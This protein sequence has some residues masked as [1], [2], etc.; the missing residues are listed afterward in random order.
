[1]INVSKLKKGIVIDHISQ[2]QG[3]KIFQELGL[4][5]L[6]NDVVVLMCNVDSDKMGKK[7]LIKIETDLDLNLDVLGLI[8]PGI[9][10]NYV[11]DGKS[12]KKLHLQLPEK[13]QGILQCKNPRCISTVEKVDP[14][15]F[16]LVDP[17]KKEYACEYCESR[18]SL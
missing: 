16:T 12:V 7:D 15:T 9:T 10:V 17:E 13:V 11:E 5:K 14:I 3:Y 1:M 4:D 6:E 8:N 18:T 2:G